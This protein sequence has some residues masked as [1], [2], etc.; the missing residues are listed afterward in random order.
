MGF[1]KETPLLI[2]WGLVIAFANGD[3]C[4][5]TSFKLGLVDIVFDNSV[6]MSP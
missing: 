6:S 4:V 1:F 2:P 5:M 3:Y